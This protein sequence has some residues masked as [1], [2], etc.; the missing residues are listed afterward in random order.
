[1]LR[2][3]CANLERLARQMLRRFPGVGRH[4]QTGDVLNSSLMRL[5]RCLEQVQPP[6]MRDFY[7]LAAAQIRRELLDLVR[8]FAR[9][10]RHEVALDPGS[11]GGAA[12]AED[13]AELERWERFHEGWEKLPA[14][15]REVMALRYYHG[16]TEEQ[17]A[18]LFG[19]SVRTVQRRWQN[20]Q[21]KLHALMRQE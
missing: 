11:A 20:A 4:A 16:W 12:A 21:V 1:L 7:T 19:V 17:V 9:L 5:L 10:N 18:E 14:E 2:G 13:S 6:S 8:H 3:T 15:E